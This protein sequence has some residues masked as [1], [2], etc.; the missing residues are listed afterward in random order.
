MPLKI[1][2]N[3]GERLLLST[4]GSVLIATRDTSLVFETPTKFLLERDIMPIQDAD[5]PAKRI[6]FIL[7]MMYI[8]ED[9]EQR[10]LQLQK[11]LFEFLEAAPS[12]EEIIDK[13]QK[14]VGDGQYFKGLKFA[15]ELINLETERINLVTQ[16][17]ADH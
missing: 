5:S 14:S 15:R 12:S 16:Q 6:Y 11:H 8:F 7:Q 1:N 10:Q 9:N 4:P 13:I 3:K 17:G 2:I